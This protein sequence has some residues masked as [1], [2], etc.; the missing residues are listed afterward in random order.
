[1]SH[2]R[3]RL[4]LRAVMTNIS[5]GALLGDIT[6]GARLKKVT[7]VNDRSAPIVGKVSDGPAPVAMG[8]PAIPTMGKAP[9]VP[10]LAPPGNRARSNSDTGDAPAAPPQ[11]G[12]LF[13]GGMPK[14]R[15]S[16]NNS[17]LPTAC[18]TCADFVFASFRRCQDRRR[19]SV[20]CF[21]S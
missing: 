1:M 8:A 9:A 11:L 4:A 15:K 13:A 17:H 7:V 2:P 20:L 16:G 6:K 3:E 10:G 21:R 19:S 5:Q 12:G 14:L 18:K